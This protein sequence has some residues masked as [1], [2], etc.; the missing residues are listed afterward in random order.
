VV[1]LEIALRLPFR[2][3]TLGVVGI[4]IQCFFLGFDHRF[5]NRLRPISLAACAKTEARPYPSL[6]SWF[7][8]ALTL[9]A[10]S[11]NGQP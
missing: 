8:R 6:T 4:Q 3:Y 1:I 9:V 5:S 7:P 10:L 2:G 11:S